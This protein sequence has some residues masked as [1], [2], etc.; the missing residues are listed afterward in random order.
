M[1]DL[2]QL[3]PASYKGVP[4]L[5][6]E[7]GGKVGRRTAEHE[8]PQ[9]DKPYV[10]DL[11]RMIRPLTFSA[12]LIGDDWQSQLNKLLGVLE[13]PG[14][15]EL[16]HPLFGTLT[17]YPRP[18]D[19]SYTLDRQ[20]MV[21]LTLEFIEAGDL[22]FPRATVNTGA[23]L[24]LAAGGWM[25]DVMAGLPD[26]SL[27]GLAQLDVASVVAQVS[28]ALSWVDGMVS[29]VVAAMGGV[30]GLVSAVLSA[31]ANAQAAVNAR[32]AKVRPVFDGFSRLTRDA[33]RSAGASRSLAAVLPALRGPVD[34]GGVPPLLPTAPRAG[35]A[36][37][38]P[39]QGAALTVAVLQSAMAWDGAQQLAQA[40]LVVAPRPRPEAP[41]VDAQ[42]QQ[43]LP[44]ADV[45]VADDLEALRD[46]L[47]E[48]LWQR[49]LLLPA[50]PVRA[51]QTLRHAVAAHVQRVASQGERL[52][53]VVPAAVTPALV[54]AYRQYGDAHR[55]DEIVERNQ[56]PHPL[57]VPVRPLRLLQ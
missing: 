24:G 53:D 42:A 40:P 9:R 52:V 41:A 56:I 48:A 13:E 51:V 50:E 27:T 39:Q 43:P 45:P 55:A 2:S 35:A 12:L 33:G 20:R 22:S 8:Y 4:F 25:D 49:A 46:T 38:T 47:N 28:Q 34:G 37:A 31:P 5:W 57:F 19:W 11:G 17:V 26:P 6:R 7:Q 15:G 1:I 54:L 36:P 10:E 30:S 18:C 44:A 3:K 29:D 32:L 23:R 14:S 16:V 21:S